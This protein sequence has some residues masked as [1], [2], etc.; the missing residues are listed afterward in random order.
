[1]KG[2]SGSVRGAT[3]SLLVPRPP[4][5][6]TDATTAPAAA[7]VDPARDSGRD[8]GRSGSDPSGAR[9][10]AGG[11]PR[12][13]RP[14]SRPEQADRS[15]TP[16][17]I[18]RRSTRPTG[19]STLDRTRRRRHRRRSQRR[20]ARARWPSPSRRSRRARTRCGSWHGMGAERPPG[21]TAALTV[22]A[23]LAPA[24]ASGAAVQSGGGW[25]LQGTVDPRG[26][27]TVAWAE[28]GTSTSLRLVDRHVGGRRR[29]HRDVRARLAP[30]RDDLPLP[31]RR[32]ERSRPD[33]TGPTRRSR[34]PRLRGPTS[35][36][37]ATTRTT[38]RSRARGGRCRRRPTRSRPARPCTCEAAP[39]PASR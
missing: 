39:M 29:G 5:A 20:R 36:R 13:G 27:A 15:R 35:P 34:R 2:D 33:A 24:V 10:H 22:A 1:M 23:P 18:R 25:S 38:A 4:S 7:A 3:S 12:R 26:S 21:L 30:G 11:T 37:P 17:S 6:T 19:S 8:P 31:H 14:R 9:R 16:R 32:A 28:Y